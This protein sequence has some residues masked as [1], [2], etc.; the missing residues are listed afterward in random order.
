MNGNS[1]NHNHN[2]CLGNWHRWGSRFPWLQTLFF[3]S[4]AFGVSLIFFELFRLLFYLRYLKL[5]TGIANGEIFQAFVVGLRFDMVITSYILTLFFLLALFLPFSKSRSIRKGFLLSMGLVFGFFF[6]LYTID[7]EFF[8]AYNSRLNLLVV[9]YLETIGPVIQTIWHEYPV[10]PYLLLWAVL[11]GLFTWVI[12]RIGQV[13]LSRVKYQSWWQRSIIFVIGLGFLIIGARGTLDSSPINWGHAYFSSHNFS[14][15]LALN[16]IFTL[17]R[18]MYQELLESNR[19]LEKKL[20]VTSPKE[21][22]HTVQ[23]LIANSSETY[24]SPEDYPLVRRQNFTASSPHRPNVVIFIMESFTGNYVG[25]LGGPYQVTPEFDR[26]SQEGILFDRFYANGLRTNRGLTATLCSYPCLPG[27]SLM[28]KVESQQPMLTVASVLK[29]LG[30]Q[31]CFIY[32]GDL[33][34]DNMEGFFR[35]HGFDRFVGQHDFP[36]EAFQT[37]WG[38]SDEMVFSRANQE[39]VSLA[40]PFIGVVLTVSA[41]EPYRIPKPYAYY[42]PEH[43][44][45]KF[46]NGLK[47]SDYALGQFFQEA[48]KQPYFDNTIF[49]IVADHGRILN[50]ETDLNLN[51]FY[52]PCLFYAPKI[53]G[54]TPRRIHTIGG[55]IDILPTLLGIL[56]QPTTHHCWGRD[57]LS[58][59]ENL[60]YAILAGNDDKI[61]FVQGPYYL[62]S[63]LSA[64]SSLYL[65]DKPT[66]IVQP[67]DIPQVMSRMERQVRIHAQAS[68]LIFIRKR[69]WNP[70]LA[71]KGK[72]ACQR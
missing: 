42:P 3:F 45:S 32:G 72:A 37:E 64:P 1:H 27:L 39:F 52:I 49:V 15:Q 2:K 57:L 28:Q 26:L 5:S 11:T 31:N 23:H 18:S 56:K 44:R 35:R 10:T 9:Q 61:G 29:P 43:D 8:G 22:I 25:A 70:E 58:I 7:L 36:K 12:F 67:A 68:Y 50:Y 13:F 41:H 63:R 60:G 71:A 17:S 51:Q 48:G 34:F 33:N 55:Q 47:Y 59:S 46:L 54:S 16:G 14:N 4:L 65:L 38:I 66:H 53:L 62:I 30:Y 40:Q 69:C 6:F 21:A 20:R 19:T 24:L